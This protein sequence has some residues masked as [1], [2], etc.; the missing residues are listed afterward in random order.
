M[1]IKTG[2]Y[3]LEAN[4][5]FPCHG[6]GW[7]ADIFICDA[8][9]FHVIT[10]DDINCQTKSSRMLSLRFVEDFVNAVVK[11][12]NKCKQANNGFIGLLAKNYK[13]YETH[14]FTQDRTTA[15]KEWLKNPD[16]VSYCDIYD[17]SQNVHSYEF[18]MNN[19]NLQAMVN[20]ARR[21]NLTLWYG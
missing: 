20:L 16:E 21:N 8:L 18:L 15:L 11:S 4:S 1:N 9:R 12:F 7:Y 19:D 5:T 13:T 6:N 10:H 14:Y 3:S 2:F 17:N